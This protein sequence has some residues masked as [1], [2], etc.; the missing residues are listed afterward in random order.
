[1]RLLIG[2]VHYWRPGDGRHGSLAPDPSARVQALRQVILQLHR[3]FGS[4]AAT[5]NHMARR[6]DPVFDQGSRL[7]LRICVSG[8]QHVLDNLADLEGLFQV[9]PCAPDDPRLLGFA[10]QAMLRDV[11]EQA[12]TAGEAYDYVVYLEDDILIQD[13]DFF[14]KLQHFNAAFGDVYLLM[15]NRIE[16]LERPGQL[17]RFYIDGDYNPAA[18]A[19]YRQSTERQL[20]LEHLG[21]V[22]CFE[23]PFNLHSGCF[24]LNTVQASRYFSNAEAQSIDTSFHGPLESAATLGMLKTFQLMK[25]SL[26]NGRFLTVEHA[27]RNFMGLVPKL[28]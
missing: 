10:C 14:L 28:S 1:M 17:S 27:G 22:V 20:C 19:Q 3:L 15:P 8:D 23:Q 2:V 5:L 9:E 12:A 7:D 13:P 26:A 4:A 18:S 21:Q 24:F 11:S 25:P 6:I 16:T